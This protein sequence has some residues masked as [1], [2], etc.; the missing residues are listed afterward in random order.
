MLVSCLHANSAV[1]HTLLSMGSGHHRHVRYRSLQSDHV[2]TSIGFPA[3]SIYCIN[4]PFIQILTWSASSLQLRSKLTHEAGGCLP[5]SPGALV[6][7]HRQMQMQM[8][9][10]EGLRLC[11]PRVATSPYLGFI[12]RC[13]SRAFGNSGKDFVDSVASHAVVAP[14]TPFIS[15]P[16]LALGHDL[17]R[18]A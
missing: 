11:D 2:T 10:N 5:A 6:R 1:A 16:I 3:R 7:T 9:L 18:R 14:G 8:Q 13:G 15:V 12:G 4:L 17:W